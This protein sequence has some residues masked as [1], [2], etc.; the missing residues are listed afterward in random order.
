MHFKKLE[1]YGF[2]SFA[3]KTKITFEPGVTAI[4]GPNGCGK[5]NIADSIKWVLGEQR[6]TALRGNSMEDVIFNGTN[7]R[8]PINIAEVYL[9]LSNENRT[10]PIE[11]DE[12]TIGRRI[13]RSGESEYLLNKQKVRLKDIQD[14]FHGTGI[15]T[16]SYSLIEQGKIDLILSSKSE[17]RRY[18]F[19]EAAGITKYKSKKQEALRKLEHTESNLLRINDIV[20]EV[21]R[22]I[23]SIERQ[24]KKAEKY[25]QGFDRLK[26]L[27]VKNS[28]NQYL[29]L[30]NEDTDTSSQSQNLKEKENRILSEIKEIN[31]IGRA[32][33][34]ERV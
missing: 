32:S 27:E 10:L 26:E 6:P 29:K 3:E 5:S 14:L 19:E 15:G 24:A 12:I 20:N 9:T 34:R 11:Y 13:Y 18:I 7:D 2:K 28:Y 30:K 23:K 22:Q 16:A 17:D 4:V 25:K 33:C 8:E 1:L 21:S 31:E